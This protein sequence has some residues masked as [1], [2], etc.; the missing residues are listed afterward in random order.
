M[1]FSKVTQVK[2]QVY[3]KLFQGMRNTID[4]EVWYLALENNNSSIYMVW[5]LLENQ[6]LP[7]SSGDRD[8]P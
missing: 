2:Y 3:N 7:S 8:Y 5:R 6:V 4:S 1:K